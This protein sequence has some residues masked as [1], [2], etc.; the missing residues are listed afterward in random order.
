MSVPYSM[1]HRDWNFLRR[2]NARGLS[3]AEIYRRCHERLVWDGP[4]PSID[5]IKAVCGGKTLDEIR[6]AQVNR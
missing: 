3:T 1:S 6:A 2:L 5:D 4:F